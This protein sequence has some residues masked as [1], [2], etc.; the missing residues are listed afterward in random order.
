MKNNRRALRIFLAFPLLPTRILL[1]LLAI[2]TVAAFSPSAFAQ[3]TIT[4]V[5]PNPLVGPNMADLAPFFKGYFFI[6]GTNF[7]QSAFVTTDGPILLDGPPALI[8][9]NLIVQGYQIGCCGPQNGQT[10]HLW[11]NTPPSG[12]LKPQ[13]RF[14]CLAPLH[15]PAFYPACSPSKYPT[16]QHPLTIP[17]TTSS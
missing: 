7:P 4:T 15:H 13:I 12:R 11:V 9:P 8:T 5:F 10:F 6:S 14:S 16:L 2:W 17:T 3:A 1:A